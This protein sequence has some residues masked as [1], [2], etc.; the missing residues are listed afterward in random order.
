MT[1]IVC[2]RTDACVFLVSLVVMGFC[3]VLIIFREGNLGVQ[4]NSFQEH[5][6][7]RDAHSLIHSYTMVLTDI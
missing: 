7:M 6:A 4:V 1:L 3:Y 5:W 2:L